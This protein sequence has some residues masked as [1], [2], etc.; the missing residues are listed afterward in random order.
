[1]LLPNEQENIDA[2]LVTHWFY[3][4]QRLLFSEKEI[5][6]IIDSE[7][8]SLVR[9][10]A[11]GGV[12]EVRSAEATR[13]DWVALSQINLALVQ[14]RV[15]QRLAE[16]DRR[17]QLLERKRMV[18]WANRDKLRRAIRDF[19]AD[20]V[21]TINEQQA[22]RQFATAAGIPATEVQQIL[23]AE[24]A[25]LVRE[26]F[27]EAVADGILDATEEQ[28]ISQLAA[29]LGVTLRL[30]E[31]DVRRIDLCR[32]A[33]ALDSGSFIPDTAPAIP[34]KLGIREVV[35]ST[36]DV[37]W[38]EVVATKRGA[39]PLAD[40]RY[41]KRICAGTVTLT[42]KQIVMVGTLDS[43]KVTLASVQRVIRHSDGI[44][45][46]RSSGK[47]VFLAADCRSLSGG[48]FALITEYA[49]SGQ[50]VLGF[51]P[52]SRFVPDILDAT[53]EEFDFVEEV[54]GTFPAN[55]S[56]TEPR[57][58]FRV[59]GD[60][61]GNRAALISQLRTGWPLRM[62]REPRNPFDKNAVAVLDQGHNMLGYLK[63]EVAEWFAP[64]LDRGKC[65]TSLVH[66]LTSSGSLIVA[67]FDA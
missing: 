37:S 26:V 10:G 43:K 27:E 63:R 33:Y 4:K 17:E 3:R 35:L 59:V 38:H 11:I 58:T 19:V 46:N 62:V 49:S 60:H 67:V 45:L 1:M 34:I 12:T 6:P 53:I 28:R 66:T 36:L 7:F 57:Y 52:T 32:L 24:S 47:S 5:G 65:F 20:G 56:R 44:F 61:V 42:N 9:S 16:R 41:L 48:R 50:P 51:D 2:R 25:K 54:D 30:S 15:D 8:L 18:D 55:I 40:G 14:E 39:M 22:V 64:I 31:E 23:A 29:S 21:L 13:N